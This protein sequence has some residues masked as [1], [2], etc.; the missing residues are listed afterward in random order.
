MEVIKIMPDY[1]CFPLW[2]MGEDKYGNTS[3]IELPI[4]GI[5]K[6]KIMEWQIL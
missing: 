1:Q 6:K 2:M 3:P 4:S 5:L